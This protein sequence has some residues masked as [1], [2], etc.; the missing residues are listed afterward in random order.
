MLAIG[1]KLTPE[2]RLIKGTGDII[3]RDNYVALAGVLMIGS[4]KISTKTKTACTNGRDE[5]YNPDFVDSLTDAEFRFV[6][7]HE[8][9]HKMY[10]HL[11]TYRDL[12]KIDHDR[13]NRACD[14]VINLKLMDEDKTGFIKMP[15]CG[16]Y[17]EQ[18]RGMSAR[19]VFALLPP[20]DN[21]DGGGNGQSPFDDH[22]W[23]EA[24]ALSNEEK[25]D[26]AKQIDEAVRQGSILAGKLGNGSNRTLEDLLETKQ[27]WKELLRDFVTTVC[28]GKDYS[29]WKRPNRRYMGLDIIMPSGISETMGEVLIGIDTSGSIDAESLA[30]FLTEVKGVCDQVKPSK[31]RLVYWDTS[32]RSEEVYLQDEL[33]N[34]TRS[35]KPKG[36]G[37]TDVRCVPAYMGEHGIKPECAI[38]LTDGYL[39]GGWGTWTVPLLWVIL[40]NKSARPTSGTSIYINN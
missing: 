22:E 23:D 34:L 18:Y 28:T 36:G 30:S 1:K 19:E 16:L 21:N 8:C 4:K 7:L 5:A 17:D 40:N 39:G 26:L 12:D 14:Y 20:S 11:T 35:T 38:I 13:A 37:G 3:G 32:V 10:Q 6:I 9:Y 2:Q 27:N 25:E 29:T 31:V 24:E 15:E 33:D